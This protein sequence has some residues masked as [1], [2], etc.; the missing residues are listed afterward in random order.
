MSRYWVFALHIHGGTETFYTDFEKRNSLLARKLIYQ[1]REKV[2][3]G[4]HKRVLL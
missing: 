4:S 2:A 1:C 3:Y